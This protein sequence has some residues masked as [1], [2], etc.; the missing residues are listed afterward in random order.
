MGASMIPDA[1][2]AA[3]RKG[4]IDRLTEAIAVLKKQKPESPALESLQAQLRA[5]LVCADMEEHGE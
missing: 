1:E 4:E 3:W 5:Q 2:L